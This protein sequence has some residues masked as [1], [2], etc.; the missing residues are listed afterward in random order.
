M[1][2]HEVVVMVSVI[3]NI[4]MEEDLGVEIQFVHQDGLVQCTDV[5][6]LFYK[7]DSLVYLRFGRESRNKNNNASQNSKPVHNSQLKIRNS[8]LA[9]K[10]ISP[11]KETY[12]K[13]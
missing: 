7:S 12:E 3:G 6:N 4:M 9:V 13:S 11:T 8:Q 10:F 5:P 2:C 1:I